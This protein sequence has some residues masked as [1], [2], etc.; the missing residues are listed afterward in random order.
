MTLIVPSVILY[1][2]WNMLDKSCCHGRLLDEYYSRGATRVVVP[3]GRSRAMPFACS[4]CK[5][6]LYGCHRDV[7]SSAREHQE[8]GR[9]TFIDENL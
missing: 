7:F 1:I 6:E 9:K 8:M 2:A 5:P 3:H 4:V